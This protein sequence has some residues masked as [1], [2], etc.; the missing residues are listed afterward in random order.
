MGG[1]L[2]LHEI[3]HEM[4]HLTAEILEG[5]RI[6]FL[7]EV[8]A[9]EIGGVPCWCCAEAIPLPDDFS[10]K[11]TTSV[12]TLVEL[13]ERVSVANIEFALN[14]FYRIRFRKEYALS[15]NDTFMRICEKH[16]RGNYIFPNA[17]KNRIRANNQ[18]MPSK[19]MR[20]PNTQ[21]RNLY[22]PVGAELDFA[23]DKNIICTVLDDSNQVEYVGKAWAISALAMHLLGGVVANGFAHF[24]YKGET[25]LERRSRLELE[26]KHDEHQVDEEMP[27][28]SEVQGVKSKIIGLEGSPLLQTTWRAF[29]SAGTNPRIAEWVH[30]VENGESVEQIARESGYAL[31][32][33]KIMISNFHLYFKVCRLN[34][35]KPEAASDV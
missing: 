21:F 7:P 12:D 30:R 3:E 19:R 24:S 34:D 29:R 28:R 22:V 25:L 4:P 33:M 13:E 11:L 32:T 6:Q 8:H 2:S 10:E 1:T 18:S 15:N 16:Y 14:L 26:G 17:K 35:I 31:S 9:A 27:P 20:S 5:I 23:K